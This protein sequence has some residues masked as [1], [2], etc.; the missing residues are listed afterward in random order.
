MNSP[1]LEKF[2]GNVV[3]IAGTG[4][5]RL[6]PLC[7]GTSREVNPRMSLSKSPPDAS[8]QIRIGAGHILQLT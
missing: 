2:Q 6:K 1:A 5:I 7:S 8:A 4:R 3:C